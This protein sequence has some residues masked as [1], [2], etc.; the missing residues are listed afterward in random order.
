MQ[1]N[2]WDYYD[3]PGEDYQTYTDSVAA[4]KRLEIGYF[5]RV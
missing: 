4:F 1:A 2:Y 3:I 5:P